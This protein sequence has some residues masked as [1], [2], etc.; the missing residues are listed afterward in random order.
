MTDPC[1]HLSTIMKHGE[2]IA[3]TEGAV[4][5]MANNIETIA[6]NVEV[7]T[8]RL[9]NMKGFLAGAAAAGG[10]IVAVIVFMIQYGGKLLAR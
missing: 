9:S 10:A 7:I 6:A 3:R 4:T 2:D 8:E 5:A 1:Q